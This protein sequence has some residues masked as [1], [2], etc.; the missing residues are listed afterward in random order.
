MKRAPFA[1][2]IAIAAAALASLFQPQPAD[3][4]SVYMCAP[5]RPGVATGPGVFKAPG[6]STTYGLNALGC[7]VASSTDYGDFLAAGFVANPPTQISTGINSRDVDS[8]IVLPA[9]ARITGITIQETS[10]GAV[11]GGVRIGTTSG[12]VDISAQPY[13]VGS[14]ALVNVPFTSM[15]KQ[16]FSSTAA[17]AIFIQNGTTANQSSIDVTIQYTFF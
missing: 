8:R 7:A 5:Q 6:S 9:G 12:A 16:V 14:S 10:G 13:T 4:A 2:L 15:A 1:F 17:Q 11:T 3:A